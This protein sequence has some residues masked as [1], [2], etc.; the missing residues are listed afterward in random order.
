[1]NLQIMAVR[2]RGVGVLGCVAAVA[3]LL[4][5][6]AALPAEEDNLTLVKTG[7]LAPDFEVKT[8]TGQEF[9]LK[10]CRGKVVLVNFFATWCG[11]CLEEMPQLET[12][13][14]QTFK[15]RGLVVIALGRGHEN[16]E[17]VKFQKMK[18][19]TFWMAGD[20]QKE[21]Y[22]KYAEQLIPRNYLIGRDG[23][24]AYQSVGYR[25]SGLKT[26]VAAVQREIGRGEYG[27]VPRG[28]ANRRDGRSGGGQ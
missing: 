18:G 1:M 10:D 15:D 6:R 20:P 14:W 8:V 27:W 19:I 24:I 21:A 7:H 26:V 17:L 4:L 9:R 28:D 23:K 11:P 2:W 22:A 13:I 12:E 3:G 16:S 5:L 25:D